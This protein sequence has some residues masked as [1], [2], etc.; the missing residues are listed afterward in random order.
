MSLEPHERCASHVCTV[1]FDLP[2]ID[3]RHGG[4]G[5]RPRAAWPYRVCRVHVPPRAVCL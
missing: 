3:C 4:A 5:R 2:S 1:L